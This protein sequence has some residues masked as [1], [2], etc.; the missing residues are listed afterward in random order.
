M[1]SHCHLFHPMGLAV[2]PSST[3]DF[4]GT[5]CSEGQESEIHSEQEVTGIGADQSCSPKSVADGGELVGGE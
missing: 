4:C 5:K 3:L 2:A 1:T